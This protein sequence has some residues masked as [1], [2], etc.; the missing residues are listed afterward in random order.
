MGT[1]GDTLARIAAETKS[2]TDNLDGLT[3]D[4]DEALALAEEVLSGTDTLQK[5]LEAEVDAHIK[6]LSDELRR[7]KKDRAPVEEA[8][9]VARN[10]I[11]NAIDDYKKMKAAG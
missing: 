8:L 4:N 7:L 5:A 3:V 6:S 10:T 9:R 11:K 2:I 1:T